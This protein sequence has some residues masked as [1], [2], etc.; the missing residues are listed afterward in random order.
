M[1]CLCL[2]KACTLNNHQKSQTQAL[3][4]CGYIARVV[5]VL[6]TPSPRLERIPMSL[7]R[8]AERQ[9]TRDGGDDDVEV[10]ALWEIRF[11]VSQL[12]FWTMLYRK[13][14]AAVGS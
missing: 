5:H 14:K 2:A 6:I 8:G 1:L 11:L 4:Y 12:R 13:T 10:S 3:F 7:K 9:L